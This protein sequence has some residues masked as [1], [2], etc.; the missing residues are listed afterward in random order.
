MALRLKK[1]YR[2][3]LTN[4]LTLL[5][6]LFVMLLILEFFT[7]AFMYEGHLPKNL[8]ASDDTLGFKHNPNQEIEYTKD[9]FIKINDIGLRG[10]NI[11]TEKEEFRILFLGGSVTFSGAI[12]YQDTYVAKVEE[13]LSDSGL[14]V[15]TY[16]AGVSGYSTYQQKILLERIF[17]EIQPNLVVLSFSVGDIWEN[18]F[19]GKQMIVKD[20]WLILGQ[21]ADSNPFVLNMQ[22]FLFEH[23]NLAR[24]LKSTYEKIRVY[25]AQKNNVPTQIVEPTINYEGINKTMELILDM[26][27]FSEERGA[28]FRIIGVADRSL[29]FKNQSS[30]Y[31][32]DLEEIEKQFEENDLDYFGLGQFF[33]DHTNP[34]LL[35]LNVPKGNVHYNSEGSRKV[36]EQYSKHLMETYFVENNNLYVF[37]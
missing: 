22:L 25:N 23:S 36:A 1:K 34:E 18:S 35:Y 15:R 30:Y 8:Y 4:F 37:S 10:E 17:D 2:T 20:G 33:F 14:N 11:P 32:I 29:V 24:V 31:H 27:H 21:Y 16:N 9:H 26:K 6:T 19:E 13:I 12:K 5:I 7:R 3:F 28:D